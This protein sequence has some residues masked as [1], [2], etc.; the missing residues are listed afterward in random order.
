[1]SFLKKINI[2]KF[3]NDYFLSRQN[4]HNNKFSINK[5]IDIIDH[6]KWWLTNKRIFKFFKS[7]NESYIYFWY[8]KI[9][10]KRKKFYT[11][12][13]HVEKKTN[14]LDIVLSYKIFIKSL[15]KEKIPIIGL[16]NKKNLFL[17]KIN[18][19]LGFT[20][21]SSRKS[22][23]YTIIKKIYKIK[24]VNKYILYSL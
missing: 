19:D 23:L 12:G 2:D 14:I 5:K 15:K 18:N 22:N 1:M 17:K 9:N 7:S 10:Y 21:I 4:F 6:Y 16:M 13:F 8:E 11:C 24:N 20:Q 3:I